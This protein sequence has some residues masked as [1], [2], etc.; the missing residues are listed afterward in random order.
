MRARR[1]VVAVALPVFLALGACGGSSSKS[2]P[3]NSAARRAYVAFHAAAKS[4]PA[5]NEQTESQFADIAGTICQAFDQGAGYL[6][7]VG[8]LVTSPTAS[9]KAMQPES[10][11]AL[12][13][14]AVLGYC[15]QHQDALPKS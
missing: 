6:D 3:V 5:I 15:P 2:P 1:A 10:A 11:G 8:K 7:I 12:T 9:G 4:D 14:A 13:T